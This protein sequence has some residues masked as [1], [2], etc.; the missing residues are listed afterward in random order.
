[1]LNSVCDA[2]AVPH[3]LQLKVFPDEE[4]Y[5]QKLKQLLGHGLCT[6]INRWA[7][8]FCTIMC[9]H[10]RIRVMSGKHSRIPNLARQSLCC[11]LTAMTRRTSAAT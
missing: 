5:H 7:C 8:N 6:G 3:L 11:C 2:V 9:C 10:L 4:M 1:M